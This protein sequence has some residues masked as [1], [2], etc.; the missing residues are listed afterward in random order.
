MTS[1]RR[2]HFQHPEVRP[3]QYFHP[4]GAIPFMRAEP[5][6]LLTTLRSCLRID[7]T[8][9]CANAQ[10]TD[11]LGLTFRRGSCLGLRR[12][13]HA[14]HGR[15]VFAD[16]GRSS[17]ADPGISWPE[18]QRPADPQSP[19]SASHEESRPPVSSRGGCCRV[20]QRAEGGQVRYGDGGCRQRERNQPTSL[21]G[22]V[23]AGDAAGCVQGVQRR[24]ISCPEEV[25]LSVEGSGRCRELPGGDR[26]S[27]GL[28]AQNRS[29]LNKAPR[30][31]AMRNFKLAAI[32]LAL[33]VLSFCQA[34]LS[35][36]GEGNVSVLYQ[37]SIDRLHAFSD[38]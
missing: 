31:A 12:Q 26:P 14:H 32:A 37:Y 21:V 36:Q 7:S 16:P 11:S 1:E 24:A 23:E 19:T 33:P 20:G 6:S 38:G 34:F 28:E 8:G 29:P 22:C 5:N 10:S 25:P 4:I 18:R 13:A 17:G 27:H 2:W 3:C 35:P 9:G 15:E 30:E